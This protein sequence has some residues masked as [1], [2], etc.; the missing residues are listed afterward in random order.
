M[1][2]PR[3]GTPPLPPPALMPPDTDEEERTFF[4]GVPRSLGD[5]E[6]FFEEDGEELTEPRRVGFVLE[7]ELELR[8]RKSLQE[9]ERKVNVKERKRRN[10]RKKGR[11]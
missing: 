2:P 11:R 5:R 9:E 8:S 4:V 10:E 1:L 7:Q 6:R 3:E